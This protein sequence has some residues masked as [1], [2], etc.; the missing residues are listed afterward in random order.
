MPENR[1]PPYF[2]VIF[3]LLPLGRPTSRHVCFPF[4]GRRPETCFLGGSRRSSGLQ[5][6]PVL[7]SQLGALL[8]GRSTTHASKK[9]SEKVLGRIL[10]KGLQKGS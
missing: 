10:G 8:K 6:V 1:K 9:G 5:A 4:S 2:G 3:S 7:E